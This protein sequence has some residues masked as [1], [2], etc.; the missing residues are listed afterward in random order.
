MSLPSTMSA[1]AITGVGDRYVLQELRERGWC[2][3]KI[4]KHMEELPARGRIRRPRDLAQIL[5]PRTA[6]PALLEERLVSTASRMKRHAKAV[7]KH[8]AA[9]SWIAQLEQAFPERII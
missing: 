9:G 5:A 6:P 2:L 1:V 3:R 7:A 4:E 8:R